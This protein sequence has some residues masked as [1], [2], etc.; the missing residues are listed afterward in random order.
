M[1]RPMNNVMLD[2]E[3]LGKKA[4][5]PILSVAAVMFEPA[6]GLVGQ[7]FYESIDYQA[8]RQYGQ[9]EEETLLWWCWF[10]SHPITDSDFTRSLILISSDH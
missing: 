10:R 3:T 8:A 7:I 2:I 1:N 4:G 5:C 6:T 9:P